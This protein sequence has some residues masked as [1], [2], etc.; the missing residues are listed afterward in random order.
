MSAQLSDFVQLIVRSSFLDDYTEKFEGF[1]W[2][3]YVNR[4]GWNSIQSQ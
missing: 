4:D 1:G 3:K 2:F